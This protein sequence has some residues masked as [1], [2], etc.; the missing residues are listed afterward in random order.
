MLRWLD[1]LPSQS[2]QSKRH[3]KVRISIPTTP[4]TCPGCDTNLHQGGQRQCPAFNQTCHL[5]Q[6]IGHFAK[7]CR[8][9]QASQPTPK[10]T[11]Q[12]QASTKAVYIKSSKERGSPRIHMS[13]IRNATAIDPAP[14]ITVHIFS[15]NES[16]DMEILPNSGADILSAGKEALSYLGKHVNNLLP[17]KIIL[18][19]VNRTRMWSI[20]KIAVTF[21][22]GKKTYTDD[23]HIYPKVTG[24][25]QSWRA[26]KGLSILP[27]CYTRPIGTTLVS[28]E[29]PPTTRVNTLEASSLVSPMP[30]SEDI[31]KEFPSVFDGQIKTMD[32]EEFHLSLTNDTKPFCISTPQSVPFAYCDKLRAELTVLQTQGIIEPVTSL[33]P[34]SGVH[35][36]L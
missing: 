10:P 7:V 24:V 14:T 21:Q 23:L 9:M 17:S 27:E 2:Q 34:Q 19:A 22:F 12:P 8:G 3:A 35:R 4:H 30:T 18:Q 32:G 13:N 29:H 16:A 1:A 5:C 33:S 20:G 36:S 26:A 25:L 28:K 6:K 15:L 31:M 11:A